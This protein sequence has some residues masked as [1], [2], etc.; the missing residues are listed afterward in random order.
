MENANAAGERAAP[1]LC[2]GITAYGALLKVKQSGGTLVN[3][4]GC[5]G[6]GEFQSAVP[7]FEPL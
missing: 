5:G 2:A 7:Q 3:I 6:V 4:I 1:L